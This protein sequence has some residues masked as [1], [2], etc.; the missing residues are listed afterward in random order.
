VSLTARRQL[1]NHHVA[2]DNGR[3]SA[4]IDNRLLEQWK[5]SR[6]HQDEARRF[7]ARQKFSDPRG[8]R[9]ALE[10]IVGTIADLEQT[11]RERA[12]RRSTRPTQTGPRSA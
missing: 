12:A 8:E 11:L 1:N 10:E 6:R 3:M 2:A 9:R 4:T 7:L 5:V